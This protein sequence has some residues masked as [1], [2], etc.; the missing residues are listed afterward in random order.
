MNILKS[1][2]GYYRILLKIIILKNIIIINHPTTVEFYLLTPLL[3]AI[4][5][6]EIF[7]WENK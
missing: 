4:S 3:M 6:L 7:L 1:P 5:V 2:V